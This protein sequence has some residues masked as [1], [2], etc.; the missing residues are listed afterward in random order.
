MPPN[1][2]LL[3]IVRWLER[4]GRWINSSDLHRWQQANL[5][6]SRA[7]RAHDVRALVRSKLVERRVCPDG[8]FEYRAPRLAQPVVPAHVLASRQI[9]RRLVERRAGDRRRAVVAAFAVPEAEEAV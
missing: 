5:G 1:D 3:R 8:R 4:Q 2:R 7:K 6:S 9:E